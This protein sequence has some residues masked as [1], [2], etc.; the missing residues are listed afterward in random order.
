ML[1]KEL[2]QLN[3]VSGD[4]GRVRDFILEHIKPYADDITIDSMGSIIAYKKGRLHSGKT[5]LV[6]AHMD[7]VG[8]ILSDIT[9][10]GFLKF[11]EVGGVDERILLTQRVS[12]LSD[13][14]PVPGVIGIKAVHL[15]SKAERGNVVSAD[16]MYID[17]GAKDKKDA[18]K[19]VSKGDYIAFD[20]EYVEFGDGCI[21]AKALD[22]R[23]GC[24]LMLELIKNTYDNDIYF[25]FNVQ[26]EVG[27][28]GARVVA[29][30]IN[31]D[32]ALVLES[33]TAADVPY[34]DEHLHC[35]T[36][37]EGPVVSVMDRASYADKYL[38]AF[39][40]DIAERSGIAYQLKKTINGGNDAGAIQ[41]STS[42]VRVCSISL[43]CRYIHSPVSTAKKCD[44]DAMH[45]LVDKVLE[46]I[47]IFEVKERI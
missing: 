24:A 20:S 41:T 37:G 28:R 43:P 11:K 44:I 29:H 17:I 32:V 39:V 36:Q 23:V 22:D 34:V 42:A 10:K 9:E 15:Q 38:G 6:C 7:E 25:C 19:Y 4:E 33:T 30:R 47:H 35:T 5:V 46:N 2:T 31:A 27:L 1:L 8:F 26:E 45:R 13:K 14:Q 3:G 12:V 40:R 16:S 18:Q 21:K